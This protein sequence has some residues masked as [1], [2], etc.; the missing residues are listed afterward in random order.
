MMSGIPLPTQFTQQPGGIQEMYNALLQ[1]GAKGY[2]APLT[3]L[4]DA[5]SKMTY[6]SLMGPQYIAKLMG[7]PNIVANSPELKDPATTRMLAQAGMGA[8]AGNALMNMGGMQQ[9]QSPLANAIAHIKNAFGFGTPSQ[10]G[11]SSNAMLQPQPSMQ[12]EAGTGSS[13]ASPQEVNS[14]LDT[15]MA[16]R[17]KN[18]TP[19]PS[20]SYEE[21]AG[22]FR[23][24]IAEGE[25]SGKL[26][27][28]DI[29]E[30]GEDQK[31]LS[32]SGVTLD[33]LINT[34]T[35][36][37]FQ[38]M[39]NKVPFF[40]D[41]QLRALS[42]IGSHE[43]QKMVGDFISTAQN[44]V[45]DT[46]NSFKGKA[47]EKEFNLA[48]K[49]KVDENDTMDVA[50]GKLR[51]L[52]TLKEIAETKNDTVIGLMEDQHMNLG[53]AIKRA[54]KLVNTKDIEDRVD[55]LISPKPSEEDIQHM[56]K[57]YNYTRDQVNQKLKKKG[58]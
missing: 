46:V 8:G 27:A 9:G 16:N 4:A 13:V 39:R 34:A 47:L 23:G 31:N 29:H 24:T 58:Y 7:N 18:G 14:I 20:H 32:R 21:N 28:D 3:T 15:T 40:Q 57:K 22:Q 49:M 53:D 56:M 41:K 25:Q 1:S 36:P 43:E 5:A 6:S 17:D 33:R 44:Y 45:A 35:S 2:Y 10:E 52:K 50:L 55:K 26:R 11:A 37:A 12:P 19:A 38:D 48:N 42:K 51:A 30:L 54:N